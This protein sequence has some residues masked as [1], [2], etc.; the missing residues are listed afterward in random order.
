M[1]KKR[2]DLSKSLVQTHSRPKYSS[3]FLFTKKLTLVSY[4]PRLRKCVVFLSII[5]KQHSISEPEN[6]YKPH[7]INY[8]NSTKNGVDVLDKLVCEYSCRRATRHWPLY[9][10]MHY[11]DLAAYN[12]LIIWA[13]KNPDWERRNPR[14]SKRKVFL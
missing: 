8:Y 11:I 10:F 4:A 13:I 7:I 6:N 2:N 9:L 12:A 3:S 5:H 1:R 14:K